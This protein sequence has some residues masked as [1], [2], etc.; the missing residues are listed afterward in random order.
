MRVCGSGTEPARKRRRST[1]AT[2]IAPPSKR[3]ARGKKPQK[4]KFGNP[5]LNASPGLHLRDVGR[6]TPLKIPYG[7]KEVAQKLGARYG[8]DGWYAPP[9]VDLAA[10]KENGWL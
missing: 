4:P 8:A 6:S 3:A 1:A 10:F 2:D 5:T 7:N 9:G